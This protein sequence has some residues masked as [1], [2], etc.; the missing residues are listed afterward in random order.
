MSDTGDRV[1]PLGDVLAG[2][3]TNWG[4]WGSDDEVGA[5][6]FLGAVE[7]L[8][9]VRSVRS[10]K[11]FTLQSPVGHPHGDPV[12]PGRRAMERYM[13][14]DESRWL[15]PDAEE[16]PGGMHWADDM[17][18]GYLQG[19]TQY[20]ALGHVWYDGRIY[21]DRDALSTVGGL[22]H[23]SVA[24]IAERGVVGRGVLIDMARHRD[25][26]WLDPGE[27]F[28][29]QDVREAAAAQGVELRPRD[30]LVVRTGWLERWYEM[31]AA[32]F[33]ADFREP[34]LTLSRELVEWFRTAEI[35]NLVTDT[36]GNETTFDPATG[37]QLPLHSALMR[38]LGIAFCEACRLA[39]LAA[40]CARDGQ[41][42]FLF[43]AAPL[44]IRRAA[45]SP[46]NP[47]VIK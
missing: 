28:D 31:D 1:P 30:I 24:S 47:V 13:V 2:Y 4:R 23:A 3:P 37:V 42:D 43:A 12:W 20:D 21:N 35:P 26:R 38:N 25:V 29:H 32:D 41:W 45:G 46:V 27:T 9:A 19:T 15:D 11:V 18:S 40:D 7:A 33:Y 22:R 36:M 10:G 14:V 34:G 44:N 8:A 16:P 17:I 39:E 6:N 5:L